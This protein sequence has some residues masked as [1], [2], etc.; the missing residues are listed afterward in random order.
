MPLSLR[1][2]A[3][4]RPHSPRVAAARR[5]RRS[6]ECGGIEDFEIE[7]MRLC[8]WAQLL[9]QRELVYFLAMALRAARSRTMPAEAA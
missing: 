8:R 7:V 2:R 9:E 4:A 5:R 3:R 1:S 6:L